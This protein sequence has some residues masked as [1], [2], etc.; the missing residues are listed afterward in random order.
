MFRNFLLLCLLIGISTASVM[1]QEVD[2]KTLDNRNTKV[3]EDIGKGLY[4]QH[5]ITLNTLGKPFP[6]Y[7]EYR[8]TVYFYFVLNKGVSKLA[9]VIVTGNIAG[10][11]EYADYLYDSAGDL[12]IYDYND[13]TRR[14]DSDKTKAYFLKKKLKKLFRQGEE[15]PADMF[16][17]D[18]LEVG[19]DALNKASIYKRLFDNMVKVQEMTDKDKKEK[20]EDK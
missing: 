18:D 11:M 13:D 4:H 8:E 3:N 12:V 5:S 2:T 6:P 1:A 9:K 10:R 7:K 19:I 16:I 17:T 14:A 20:K 15:I